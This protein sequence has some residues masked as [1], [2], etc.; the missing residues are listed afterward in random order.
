MGEALV[1]GVKITCDTSKILRVI[2][3][4]AEGDFST[5]LQRMG[6][7]LVRSTNENF[8]NEQSPDGE[9]WKPLAQITKALRRRGKKDGE[10]K[11]LQ[12]SGRLRNSVTSQVTMNIDKTT[13]EFGTNVEYGKTHQFGGPSEITV[14]RKKNKK[15]KTGKNAGKYRKRYITKGVS[16]ATAY[17][18][19]IEVPARPFLGVKEA[20][21]EAFKK[22]LSDWY[23]EIFNGA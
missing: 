10:P 20:D 14:I 7:R 17:T 12:D 4:M 5:P 23:K 19:T 3:K 15:I 1:V 22:I 21:K 16:M 6:Q 13:L 11:I 18:E 9:P 8:R 2:G